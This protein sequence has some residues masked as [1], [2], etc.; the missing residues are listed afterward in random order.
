M[1]HEKEEW[2]EER[3]RWEKAQ[4]VY[5]PQG[6]FWAAGPW[7]AWDCRSYGKRE[8]WA[9]LYNIPD[10]WTDLDACM[11][12]PTTIKGVSLKRPDRCGYVADSSHIHGFWMVDWNQVDCKPRHDEVTD[13]VRSG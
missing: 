10:D 13:M 2:R 12:M 3:E 8:Y 1:E 5:V 9:E 7:P 6:A 11:N 4:K